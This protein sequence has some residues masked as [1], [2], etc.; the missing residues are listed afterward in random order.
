ML[1]SSPVITTHRRRVRSIM[2]VSSRASFR[3][4]APGCSHGKRNS[5]T[6]F[7]TEN[8]IYAAYSE[9]D[10]PDVLRILDILKMNQLTVYDPHLDALPSQ[11]IFKAWLEQGIHMSKITVIFLT[12][13]F[14][15]HV[16]CRYQAD[17]AVVRYAK[18]KG[19]HRVILV[20]LQSCKIPKNLHHFNCVYAWRF[21]E[22]PEE[23]YARILKAIFAPR[24]KFRRGTMLWTNVGRNTAK[25]ANKRINE[26]SVLS[27]SVKQEKSL[28]N[29]ANLVFN[30]SKVKLT[31]ENCEL[32]C[33]SENCG[34]HCSG[35]KIID[36]FFP[37]IK[38][39]RYQQV[40]CRFCRQTTLRKNLERHEQT[41]CKRRHI[42]CPNDSCGKQ[43]AAAEMFNHE[44]KC[45]YK[46]VVCP[47]EV[48]GCNGVFARKDKTKH[49]EI[50]DYEKITLQNLSS[51][52]T[53]DRWICNG[54]NIQ[55][56]CEM[57]HKCVSNGRRDSHTR[58]CF[59][60]YNDSQ[61]GM[62]AATPPGT[63]QSLAL[64]THPIPETERSSFGAGSSSLRMAGYRQRTGVSP[65]YERAAF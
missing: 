31:L 2:S 49:L 48:Y 37:H 15:S 11:T 29:Y 26:L 30:L 43:L 38:R 20:M 8:D 3:H 28:L 16:Y 44:R 34:F 6:K 64:G 61:T 52:F 17:N 33:T 39:C 25:I 27:Q 63:I 32:K 19:R 50:C 62:N 57:C 22:S 55:T 41:T 4:G 45:S 42:K 13:K 9:E 36:K 53:H 12:K 23:Q 51:K 24:H 59:C 10:Q 60:D 47:N 1:L 35:D 40:K 54:Q 58:S 18:T 46:I 5:G 56:L 14:I 7:E 21:R 65:T